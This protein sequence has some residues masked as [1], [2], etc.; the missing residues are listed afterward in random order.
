MKIHMILACDLDGN[1]GRNVGKS[2]SLLWP[3]IKRDMEWFREK[4][5]ER[6]LL[7]GNTTYR[8]MPAPLKDRF[9]LVLTQDSRLWSQHPLRSGTN[10]SNVG[11][12][13]QDKD[14]CY[15]PSIHH[16]L[17][18]AHSLGVQDLMVVGGLSV[19]EA[20]V[21]L[22]DQTH[23]T[24]IRCR[25]ANTDAEAIGVVN[26]NSLLA[27]IGCEGFTVVDN[28]KAPIPQTPA[29]QSTF[30]NMEE[31]VRNQLYQTTLRSSDLKYPPLTFLTVHHRDEVV[32][33]DQRSDS[34]R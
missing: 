4:T 25:Y 1:I 6:V 12:L 2:S 15:V 26:S 28:R 30:K 9:T 23:L 33:I 24:I 13:V 14:A 16:A 22:V 19:Y 17:I 27:Q 8:G 20:I 10:K 11:G 31:W 18:T 32:V 34:D 21:D 3:T 7:M 29:V 5:M